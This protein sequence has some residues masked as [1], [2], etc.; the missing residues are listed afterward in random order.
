VVDCNSELVSNS[1]HRSQSDFGSA[2][3]GCCQMSIVPPIPD[4]YR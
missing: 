3:L 2:I 1:F 4:P